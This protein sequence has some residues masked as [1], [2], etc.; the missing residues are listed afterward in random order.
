MLKSPFQEDFNMLFSFQER[1]PNCYLTSS[2]F[3][4]F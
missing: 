2:F 1:A 4:A 3:N